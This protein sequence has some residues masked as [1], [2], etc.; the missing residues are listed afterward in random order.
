[1]KK[2]EVDAR[3]LA[4]PQP[5]VL[6]KKALEDTPEGEIL[7]LVDTENAR[8][9]VVR[10]AE[11]QGCAA[12]ARQEGGCFAVFNLKK[13]PARRSRLQLLDHLFRTGR[14]DCLPV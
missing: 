1:M 13:R 14:G 10:L 8:D 2:K 5:V 7:V 11:S 9:N 4:C 12:T 3:G 6:T